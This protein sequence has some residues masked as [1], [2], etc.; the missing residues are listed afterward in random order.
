MSWKRRHA[1]VRT[2]ADEEVP[3]GVQV[4][5]DL[6]YVEDPT[7]WIAAWWMLPRLKILM[8][9]PIRR[10]VFRGFT[11]SS[12]R[13]RTTLPSRYAAEVMRSAGNDSPLVVHAKVHL[14][15]IPGERFP[16]INRD[17]AAVALAD[18]SGVGQAA[19]HVLKRDRVG[20]ASAHLFFSAL[21]LICSRRAIHCLQS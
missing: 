20:C 9:R 12:F 18:V 10:L 15:E 6:Q 7:H 19:Q 4:A 13:R 17:A 5:I 2:V 1:V 3:E 11:F 14:A 21:W 16:A 8:Y